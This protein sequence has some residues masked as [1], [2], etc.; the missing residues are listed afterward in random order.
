M[1]SMD[2]STLSNRFQ[3]LDNKCQ[4]TNDLEKACKLFMER[5]AVG[6]ETEGHLL[7]INGITEGR[8]DHQM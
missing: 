7:V 2:H 8:L 4:N 5:E 3:V 1:D 6:A